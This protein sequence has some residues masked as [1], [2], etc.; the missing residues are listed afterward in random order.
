MSFQFVALPADL[1]GAVSQC[2]DAELAR[3]QAHRIQADAPASYPCRVSLRHAETGDAMLLLNHEHQSANSPYRARGPIFVRVGKPTA[4]LAAGEVPVML[5][6]ALLSVR[7]Y[8]EEGWIEFAD[9]TD[10][11]ELEATIARA[12]KSPGVSYLHLHYAR[13]GCYICRVDRVPT[14]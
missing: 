2:D 11:R 14:Q 9:V 4:R 8:G 10:G 3:R 13:Q 6:A 12:F 5:R 1:F 7:G